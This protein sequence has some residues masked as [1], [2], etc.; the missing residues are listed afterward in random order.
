MTELTPCVGCPSL[1]APSYGRVAL[2][3]SPSFDHDREHGNQAKHTVSKCKQIAEKICLKVKK[4]LDKEIIFVTKIYVLAACN[5][6]TTSYCFD[7]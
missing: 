5:A 4:F 6:S 7:V 2:S 1:Q 3:S